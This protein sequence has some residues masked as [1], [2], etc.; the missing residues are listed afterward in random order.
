MLRPALRQQAH[1][2]ESNLHGLA[3]YAK[4]FRKRRN[5]IIDPAACIVKR[6]LYGAFTDDSLERSVY[7]TRL[8]QHLRKERDILVLYRVL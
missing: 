7:H 5:F 3:G 8:Y 6:C 2:F 1:F 4:Q